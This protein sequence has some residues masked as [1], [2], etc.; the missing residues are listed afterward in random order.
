MIN[1]IFITWFGCGY[2]PLAPGTMG[3]IGA[4]PL[5][6]W[7]MGFDAFWQKLLF[8]F[9][10]MIFACITAGVDQKTATTKDPSYV[11]IDEVSGM[12]FACLWLPKSLTALCA[13][14]VLFRLFDITKPFPGNTLDR[15][16][17]SAPLAKDRGTFIVLDDVVAG[18]YAGVGLYFLLVFLSL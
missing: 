12:L 2:V 5:C 1:R 18:L 10:F 3:S 13:A 7:M 11:V 6:Y 8:A 15:A 9:V 17:K 14:F 4:L 16:S